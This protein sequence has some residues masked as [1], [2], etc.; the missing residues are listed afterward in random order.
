MHLQRVKNTCGGLP[1]H[2]ADEKSPAMAL[3]PYLS[4]TDLA[5]EDR[6]LLARPINLFRSLA[7]S[8]EGLR[9]FHGLG[10]WIRHGCALDPRLR[11]LA[12]LQVGYLTSSP[13]EWSH[14]VKI[15]RDFGVTDDDLRALVAATEGR[16][17]G[18]GELDA[19]VLRAARELTQDLRIADETW[20]AL[21]E[22]LDDARRVDLVIVASFYSAV[23]RVLGGLRV[24]VEPDYQGYLDQFPL[25]A[26]S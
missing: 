11:E 4:E 16:E 18:L 13:Y 9:R 14:H 2:R 15:G 12:I 7:H 24:D 20:A 19:A 6:E 25:S 8:P 10:D 21:G 3:V 23:V 1:L 5:P 26:P 22:H 17:H